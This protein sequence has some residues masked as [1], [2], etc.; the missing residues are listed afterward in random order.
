MDQPAVVI[1]NISKRFGG[2]QALYNV[3]FDIAKGEVHA[4]LGENGAGKSTLIKIISGVVQKDDGSVIFDGEELNVKNPQQARKKGI[5]V[6]YQELSLVSELTVVENI[7]ASTEPMNKF[8]KMNKK[9]LPEHVRHILTR[10]NINPSTY[11]RNLGI[12]MQQMVEIA[13]AVSRDC[14]LLILDEPTAALTNEESSELFKLID[15]LKSKGVTIIYISH[16]ISEVMA[17]SDSVSVLKD[18]L[19]VDTKPISECSETMLISMM[20]GREFSDMYPPLCN[21]VGDIVLE[22]NNLTGEGFKDVSFNL[23]RGEI[24]G[25]AGLSGAGRT[26]V[27][28]TIFG[29]A[30]AESGEV[31][32]EGKPLK[33]TLPIDAIRAGIGYLPE[34]RKQV[35]IFP[36]MDIKENTI[37]AVIDRIAEKGLL[38]SKKVKDSTVDINS[39]LQTKYGS[40]EHKINSLSGG[41]QQKVIL[42][43]WL[44][45]DPKVLIVDEPTRGIDVGAKHEIYLILRDLAE[46]GMGII[47]VSSELPEIV[48]MAD[49]VITMY[50]GRV[51]SESKND[52]MLADV[53]GRAIIGMTSE[54]EI[55]ETP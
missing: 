12:G 2:T 52:A 53:V 47:L 9:N 13:A 3:S 48:G 43:R 11:V 21:K 23:R 18:G 41:N 24:L 31:K 28:T 16:K 38:N 27:M 35:A 4:L 42:S 54:N 50:R 34:D 32:L 46:N 45:S 39:K 33:V 29:A 5:N 26:E 15:D 55:K 22:V 17:I 37:A 7:L 6:V 20:I 49:R 40:I 30:K 44:L 1:K 19:Y 14:K 25:F 36:D 8:R 51:M 10:F